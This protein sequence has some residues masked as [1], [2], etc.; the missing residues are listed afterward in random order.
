MIQRE[1]IEAK[2][3]QYSGL[4][5]MFCVL[6]V[7]L[8]VMQMRHSSSPAGSSK[9]SIIAMGMNAILDAVLCVSHMILSA[10]IS[11]ALNYSYV[12]IVSFLQLIIFGVLE[13][14]ILMKILIARF[15]SP[16]VR[17]WIDY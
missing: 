4:A 16:C 9:I 1:I 15:V 13:M 7:A 5:T 11:K 12:V 8:L 2:V 17:F 3:M 10:A 14:R 6:Q